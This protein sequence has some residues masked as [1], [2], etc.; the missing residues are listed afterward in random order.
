MQ[1]HSLRDGILRVMT[2]AFVLGVM[3]LNCAAQQSNVMPDVIGIRP[4]MAIGDAYKVLKAHDAK[5]AIKFGQRRIPAVSDKPITHAFLYS[6][7]SS[8]EDMEVILADITFPPSQQV[9]W[10]VTR[11]IRFPE[12]KEIPLGTLLA[13]LRQ[14]YGPEIPASNP[15]FAYWVFDPQGHPA[16]RN[17]GVNLADCAQY[18]ELPSNILTY[19][20]LFTDGR[21]SSESVPGGVALSP[22]SVVANRDACQ[23][24]VFVVAYLSPGGL[25]RELVGSIVV[26]ITDLG[27][28]IRAGRATQSVMNN[29]AAAQQQKE[30]K[31]AQQQ[32]APTF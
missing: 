16:N 1:V 25:H 13:A 20:S 27:A 22:S 30:L 9:V 10:R 23:A 32:A 18:V 24:Y 8:T 5:G 21:P 6:P 26:A 4:G 14:K 31:K 12:G 28:G 17:A 15:Q 11:L 29:A 19:M 7:T 2:A 3:T